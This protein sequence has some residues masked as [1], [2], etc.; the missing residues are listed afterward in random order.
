[1]FRL[2]ICPV[3]ALFSI[4]CL[5]AQKRVDEQLPAVRQEWWTNVQHQASLPEQKLDWAQAS[6]RVRAGNIKLRAARLDVT[7]AQE[8]ARQVWRDLIPTLNLRSGVNRRLGDLPS[9]GFSDVTFSADGFLNLPGIANFSSR[10]FATQLSLLRAETAEALEERVQLIELFKL[11]Q[12]MGL[13]HETVAQAQVQERAARQ[14]ENIDPALGGQIVA[15]L[16]IERV[17]LAQEG[18]ALNLQFGELLGD[19]SRRWRVET[20][21]LPTF[22][23]T[24]FPLSDTN[25]VGR[26]QMRLVAVELAGGWG[27]GARNQTPILA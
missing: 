3:L 11:F 2:L 4:G 20:N 15:D 25:R 23:Y 8:S 27:A 13:W 21:G 5:S 14:L 17:S 12:K 26:L 1:M 10:R 16:A 22:D 24:Q 18:D 19:R 9:T 6:T 7:N